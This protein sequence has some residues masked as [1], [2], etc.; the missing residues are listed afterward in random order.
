MP[1]EIDSLGQWSYFRVSTVI[2]KKYNP[3]AH[4]WFGL[5]DELTTASKLLWDRVHFLD[6]TVETKH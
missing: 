2:Q 5:T 1:L 3:R 4:L 6:Q